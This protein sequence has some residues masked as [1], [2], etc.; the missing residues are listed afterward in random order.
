MHYVLLKVYEVGEQYIVVVVDEL[1][2]RWPLSRILTSPNSTTDDSFDAMSVI[3]RH[4]RVERF[5]EYD[6]SVDSLQYLVVHA[7]SA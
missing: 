6:E 5:G 7:V 2:C 3:C 4:G 1:R